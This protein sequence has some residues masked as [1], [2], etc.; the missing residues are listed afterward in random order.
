[1]KDLKTISVAVL[2][3]A[4]MFCAP[5]VHSQEPDPIVAASKQKSTEKKAKRIYTDDDMP[6][7]VAPAPE[8]APAPAPARSG[9]PAAVTAV[10]G[11]AGAANVTAATAPTPGTDAPA[12]VPEA[13][14][15]K[16]AVL[17]EKL[18]TV[19]QERSLLEHKLHALQEKADKAD[20]ENHK[21][22]YLEAIENQQTTLT[23]YDRL[24]QDIEKQI[25]EEKAKA[26]K[27][28]PQPK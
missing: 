13:A 22:I 25:E 8:K 11:Q 15:D 26:K 9:S 5:L 18:A 2:M 19:K 7:H 4:A 24:R 23:E 6:Q 27:D 10:L 20:T 21:R 28:A 3:G 14:P 17:Q 1:M 12:A 16:G